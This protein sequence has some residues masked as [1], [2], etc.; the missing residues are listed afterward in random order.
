MAFLGHFESALKAGQRAVD[1]DP[2][3]WFSYLQQGLTFYD[4]RQN[5]EALAAIQHALVLK[6]G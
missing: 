5:G 6:P 2:Q 3:S 4:A 1:L